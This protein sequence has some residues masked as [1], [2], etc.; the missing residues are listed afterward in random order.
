M[1]HKPQF[2]ETNHMF[3]NNTVGLG[4]IVYYYGYWLVWLIVVCY[5]GA[6]LATKWQ[7]AAEHNSFK[8]AKLSPYYT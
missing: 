5:I 2:K 3:K 8:G 4:F 6:Y 7:V 1:S